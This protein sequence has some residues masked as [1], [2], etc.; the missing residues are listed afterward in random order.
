MALQLPAAVSR[1]LD[2]VTAACGS[3][4]VS[5]VLFG[6]VAS[7]DSSNVSDVDLI[8][9]LQ[10]GTPSETVNRLREAIA[11]LEVQFGF[12]PIQSAGSRGWRWR[13]ERATGHLFSCFVCTRA[14]FLSGDAAAILGLR[15]WE[16]PF[17]DRIIL[18]SIVASAVTVAGEDLVPQVPVPP[19]RRA[20]VL[21]ALFA[22]VCRIVL[23]AAVFPVLSD[24][25]KFA[26]GA[27]K[28]SVRSCYFC[29]HRRSAPLNEEIAFFNRRFGTSR[30]LLDLMALRR[31]YR[32]SFW[33]ILR[34]FPAVV[35]LQL[36]T[37][38]DF[39]RP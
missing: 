38:R 32:P 29:Y 31:Q 10:D 28:H 5:L 3:S 6:S 23:S 12:R 15:R 18:A 25:T 27:L 20:D 2:A 26:M 17:V 19:I 39:P 37:A 36:R 13:V 33:F 4:L 8:V 30:T 1:H 14:Q 9:V 24:A 34:C 22:F 35:S 11:L 16:A 21:K 7:G